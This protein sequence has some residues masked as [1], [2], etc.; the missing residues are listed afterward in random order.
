MELAAP[1]RRRPGPTTVQ[2]YGRHP[3]LMLATGARIGAANANMPSDFLRHHRLAIDRSPCNVRATLRRICVPDVRRPTLP[4][5]DP[6]A[7]W[8]VATGLGRRW[9]GHLGLP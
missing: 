7:L 8:V 9:G 6:Q 5:S 4:A 3:D 1:S 2:R